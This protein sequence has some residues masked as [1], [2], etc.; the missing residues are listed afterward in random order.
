MMAKDISQKDE[1]PSDKPTNEAENQAPQSEQP[2][3]EVDQLQL[4]L[5]ELQK[6]ADTYKDQFL[7]KA[8]EL[9]NFK[10]RSE[11]DFVNLIKNANEGLLTALL[12]ILNDFFRSLKSGKEQKDHDA[13]YN[14]VELI[15]NKFSKILEAQGLVPFES[16]GKPFDVEYHDAVLLV[17]REDVPPNTVLEEVERGYMLRDKVLRHAKVVVSA[18]PDKEPKTE[19]SPT[20]QGSEEVENQ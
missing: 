14:G 7:R 16:V 1:Q 3:S 12:P 5:E 18:S 4:K 9:E 6:A 8:A 19:D 15:F 17:P 11:A 10:R 13:F 20:D 2:V